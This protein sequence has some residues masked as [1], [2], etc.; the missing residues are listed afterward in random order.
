MAYGVLMWWFEFDSRDERVDKRIWYSQAL[1]NF[2]G[3]GSTACQQW[4][5]DWVDQMWPLRM[6]SANICSLYK[7]TV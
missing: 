5:V 4:N 3:K 2:G 7:T 1:E 6:Q